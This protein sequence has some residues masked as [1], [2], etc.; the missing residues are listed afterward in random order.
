MRGSGFEAHGL[1]L[2]SSGLH[3]FVCQ[4]KEVLLGCGLRLLKGY[5][6]LGSGAWDPGS[7]GL[8]VPCSWYRFPRLT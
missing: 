5:A 7:K 8:R 2:L 3:T 4:I 1:C 6:S